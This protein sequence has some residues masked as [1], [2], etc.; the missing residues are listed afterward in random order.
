[1]L[2]VGDNVMPRLRSPLR[3]KAFEI[4]LESDGLKALKQ[5]ASELDVAASQIRKWKNIDR[6]DE[7]LK[8]NVTNPKGN[9]TKRVGAPKEN[10]NAVGNQG[11]APSRNSNAVT[12]GFFRKYFPDE[13][14]ELLDDA[15][16][17]NQLDMLWVAIQTQFTAIIH[18]QKV[19]FVRDQ[20]DIVKNLKRE[21]NSESAF[22]Q[23]WE[24]QYPW[25]RQA[26]FLSAQSRA[27]AEL[28]SSIKDFL[29]LADESDVRR[30]KL[31]NMQKDI[32]L[33][34]AQIAKIN[35]EDPDEFEDDGFMDALKERSAEVWNDDDNEES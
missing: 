20:D 29:A 19:M 11:G 24:F 31:E 10:Q 22:E 21:R 27:I 25:D 28:R 2:E 32:E 35:G 13:V 15:E 17:I 7:Q 8:S 5:I 9:V 30:L 34:Q 18:A 4:W 12:H 6:W 16:N 26:N 33:K 3:D 14:Q 23:E 1:M